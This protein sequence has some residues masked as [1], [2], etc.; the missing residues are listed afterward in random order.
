VVG[1]AH[2]PKRQAAR[3]PESV[4]SDRLGSE[5]RLPDEVDGGGAAIYGF[6]AE[7]IRIAP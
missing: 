5:A 6:D 2:D 4:D 7:S 1:Q 3:R